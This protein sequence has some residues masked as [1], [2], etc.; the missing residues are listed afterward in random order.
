MQKM[1]NH[2]HVI[3]WALLILFVASLTVG[4][5]VGGADLL[6][7]FSQKSRLK[8]AAGIVDGEKLDAV[9]F[10]EL[11]Q[12]E[13]NN[14]R[15]Q[16]QELTESDIEQISDYIWNSYVNETL[17]NKQI[18]RYKL[19]A[20]DN[21]IYEVLVNNPPQFLIQNEA[22][23]T[24]GQFDYQKYLNALNNP[25]GNEWLAVEEYVRIYLPFEKM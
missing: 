23:Q 3:L 6:D 1:R 25:Q 12:N 24:N 18:D 21:E 9:R 11:I 22:F 2:T 7:V 17:I 16:N 10:S 14:Y 19:Y 8:D 13:I 20:T 15:D 4:G 5:L